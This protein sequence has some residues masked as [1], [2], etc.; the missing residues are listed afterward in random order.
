[1]SALTFVFYIQAY[2]HDVNKCASDSLPSSLLFGWDE[3]ACCG[4]N[5][6]TAGR[7]MASMSLGLRERA[8]DVREQTRSA[9]QRRSS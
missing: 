9:G 6:N 5:W 2:K 7:W 1:M 4:V 8:Y 3:P